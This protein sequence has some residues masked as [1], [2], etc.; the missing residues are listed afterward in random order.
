MAEGLHQDLACVLC[1]DLYTKPEKLAIALE[2]WEKRMNGLVKVERSQE[3]H[4]WDLKK[5]AV[6][7]R[8]VIEREFKELQQFLNQRE[9]ALLAQL[10]EEETASQR[11]MSARIQ[12]IR[13][14]LSAVRNV[15]NNGRARLAQTD[16]GI[17]EFLDVLSA[18][19]SKR[20]DDQGDCSVVSKEFCLDKF[21]GPTQYLT[22]T[23]MRSILKLDFID[24][25][26]LDAS[27]AH[28]GL[29]IISGT[30]VTVGEQLEISCDDP[31]RFQNYPVVLG[32]QGFRSGR[33]YW[34]VEVEDEKEWIIGVALESIPKKKED[35]HLPFLKGKI[36]CLEAM[37]IEDGP[38]KASSWSRLGVYLEY[39][40]GQVSFYNVRAGS[41]VYTQ[42]VSFKEK[43]YPFF[44]YNPIK[45]RVDG[46]DVSLR[47]CHC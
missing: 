24:S 21:Q 35:H 42:R 33:H 8:T 18:E 30:S 17:R 1:K 2:P 25:I 39:K 46:Q 28:P 29:T 10:D 16:R 5:S 13:E 45:S 23:S 37:E 11:D 19:T 12:Q 26:Q 44:Q 6:G 20:R 7:F 36:W 27:T 14:N 40:K 3:K 9:S 34:E 38:E 41:H 4:L 31:K 32:Q 22:W 15:V 43:V 47:I